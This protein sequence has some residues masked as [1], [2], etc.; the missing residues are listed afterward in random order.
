MRDPYSVLG[1][2][3]GADSAAIK[4]AY[5]KLAKKF[6]P[7]QNPDDPKAKERFAEASAAY[8]IVGDDEKRRAFDRGEIDAQGNPTMA[9]FNPFGGRGSSRAQGGP[10]PG[11][12]DIFA[13]FTQGRGPG[14]RSAGGGFG[15]GAGGA[16][17][18]L[19]SMFGGGGPD[20]GGMGG[21]GMGGPG[22]GGARMG[23][24]TGQQARP[25]KGGDVK[26]RANVSLEEVLAADKVQVTIPGQGSVKIALPKG[27][28]DGQTIRLK[29][30]GKPSQD[31]GANGDAL[32]TVRF[33]AHPKFKA[34]GSTLLMDLPVT[35]DE[36]VLGARISVA[37]LDG[38][39]A[40][41]LPENAQ[42][43]R[44]MRL[45]GRGLPTAKIGERGD[46]MIKVLIKLPDE[47]DEAL[48]AL[49]KRW[50]TDGRYTVR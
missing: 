39:V 41:N 34:D 47:G 24:Q 50:R 5:R 2:A 40:L 15:G 33:S 7:D 16:E 43:G 6:H 30:K 23:G 44:T 42:S 20:L 12:E 1:V 46:L 13:T 49:M 36:A 45:K 25:K 9:G 8:D 18:I 14:Y 35:L 48:A 3:K 11:F 21:P 38:T 28:E 37:T 27:V 4:S 31:G 26:V 22:M 29:G 10:N 17:D 19:K 32:V